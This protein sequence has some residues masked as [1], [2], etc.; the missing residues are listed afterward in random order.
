MIENDYNTVEDIAVVITVANELSKSLF[1]VQAFKTWTFAESPILGQA[2]FV[3][4]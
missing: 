3:S 4:W 1:S 2:L